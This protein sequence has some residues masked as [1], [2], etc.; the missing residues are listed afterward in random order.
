MRMKGRAH[1]DGH[2]AG[3]SELAGLASGA[4]FGGASRSPRTAAAER[5]VLSAATLP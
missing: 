3:A 2:A 4:R 1:N 5:A